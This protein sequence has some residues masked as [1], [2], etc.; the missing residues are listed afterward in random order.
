MHPKT[1]TQDPWSEDLLEQARRA[2]VV[3]GS[4]CTCDGFYHALWSTFRAVKVS[5][6][7]KA[8][9]PL[10]AS[11]MTPFIRDGA[12]I[13]I[14]GAADPGVLCA[15]GRIYAPRRPALT[16]IDKCRAPLELIREFAVHKRLTCETRNLDLV[17][18]DGGQQWDQIVLHYTPLFVE[19]RLHGRLFRNVALSLS[20]GGT[21][22]CA[23]MTSAKVDGDRR[24]ELGSV[25]FS[26]GWKALQ[27]SPLADLARSPEFEQMFRSYAA[28][29]GM[30]RLGLT[31]SEALR[32]ALRGAGLRILSEHTTPRK[33]RVVDG[34]AIVDSNAIIIAER[35]G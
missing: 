5:N 18:L 35:P 8:E 1:S 9:E 3:G 15:V 17:E 2:I 4:L 11:L 33:T 26:Y 13:M 10:L 27:E 20:P 6:S 16:V 32:E 25:F 23:A 30:R 31:T 24:P 12:R 14:G 22:V 19:R 28:S 21:L 7:L 29:W 34:A